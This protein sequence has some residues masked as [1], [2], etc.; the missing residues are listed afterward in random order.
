MNK[1]SYFQHPSLLK[2]KRTSP[3]GCPVALREAQDNLKVK[4]IMKFLFF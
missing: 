2:G 1:P 3:C 4:D